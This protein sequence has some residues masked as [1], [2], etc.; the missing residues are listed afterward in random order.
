LPWD[1]VQKCDLAHNSKSRAISIYIDIM[2][3]AISI[4]IDIVYRAISIYI[5]ITQRMRL[6]MGWLRLVGSLEL[7]VFFAKE[8][9]KR[10]DILQERP[11][12]LKSLLIVATPYR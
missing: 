5:H 4:Y 9:Y 12:I 11:I 7:Q 1:L 3:R 2:Y 10:D 6:V 8:P